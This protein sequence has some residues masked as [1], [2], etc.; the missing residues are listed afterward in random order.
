MDRSGGRSGVGMTLNRG[1]GSRY[2]VWFVAP[3]TGLVA[4]AGLAVLAAHGLDRARS[5][6]D[7]EPQVAAPSSRASAADVPADDLRVGPATQSPVTLLR[8]LASVTVVEPAGP[9]SFMAATVLSSPVWSATTT[10]AVVVPVPPPP[11][12]PPP[13]TAAPAP[14][15]VVTPADQ[16][17]PTSS[18]IGQDLVVPGDPVVLPPTG[19]PAEE[20]PVP[21]VEEP[22][23]PPEA[24]EAPA[25]P[26]PSEEPAPTSEEVAAAT[27]EPVP[28]AEPAV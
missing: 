24:A 10:V 1:R 18:P 22:A 19:E 3:V 6:A 12:P 17:P 20:P 7:A 11:P 16:P 9:I 21:P 8:P 25:D 26:A 2:Q 28:A 15:P 23:P 5:G 14:P 13:P 27:A 4:G